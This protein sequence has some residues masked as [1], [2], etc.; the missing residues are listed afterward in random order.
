MK[1]LIYS[2][3]DKIGDGLQKITFIQ[4][5]KSI[6]PESHITYTTTKSTEYIKIKLSIHYNHI[7]TTQSYQS[8]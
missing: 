4:K 5:L 1:I 2:Y 7:H 3:N 6:Y 8:N